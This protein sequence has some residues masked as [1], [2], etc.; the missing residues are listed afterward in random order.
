ME[1]SWGA[2]DALLHID[3]CYLL[4]VGDSCAVLGTLTKYSCTC[5]LSTHSSLLEHS[6]ARA[7]VHAPHQALTAAT[8]S[9]DVKNM[10][11]SKG[12]TLAEHE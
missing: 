6:W 12:W 9:E 4:C 11:K 1:R 3:L 10:R 2:Y 8:A 5:S 7:L